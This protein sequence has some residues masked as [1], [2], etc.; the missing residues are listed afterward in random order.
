MLPNAFLLNKKEN[1]VVGPGR[2]SIFITENQTQQQSSLWQWSLIRIRIGLCKGLDKEH[3]G[4]EQRNGGDRYRYGSM[5]VGQKMTHHQ[6]IPQSL[7]VLR[8]GVVQMINAVQKRIIASKLAKT[9][10]AS[11]PVCLIKLKS[12]TQEHTR[13]TLY[14]NHNTCGRIRARVIQ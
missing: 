14:P 6:K 11:D 8:S 5:S 4:R 2:N 9:I 7:A 1:L 13:C 10:A 12:K 3:T